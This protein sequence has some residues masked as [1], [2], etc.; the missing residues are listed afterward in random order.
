MSSSNTAGLQVLR[1]L[2]KSVEQLKETKNLHDLF[3]NLSVSFSAAS[4]LNNICLTRTPAGHA[5]LVQQNVVPMLMKV[6]SDIKDFL[7]RFQ[8]VSN[9]EFVPTRLAF[10]RAP[11][12]NLLGP[13]YT[14]EL[15]LTSS[16][17]GPRSKFELTGATSQ[18]DFSD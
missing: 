14:F 18:F 9:F 1:P 7:G 17:L 5:Q 12:L 10:E 4:V 11:A 8:S 2:E 3:L 13:S 16:F 6:F 15:T